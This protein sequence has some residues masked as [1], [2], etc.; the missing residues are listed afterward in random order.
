MSNVIRKLVDVVTGDSSTAGH[1][2]SGMQ[3]V[4]SE[5]AALKGRPI[6]HL[7]VTAARAQPSPAD[8]VAALLRKQGKLHTAPPNY[9][10]HVTVLLP[11]GCE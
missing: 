6:E 1:P 11:L 3:E 2:D 9:P 8:A 7:D 4:L 10:Q 5:L